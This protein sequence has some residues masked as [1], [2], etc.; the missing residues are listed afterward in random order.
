MSITTTFARLSRTALSSCSV[1][2]R[3]RCDSIKRMIGTSSIASRNGRSAHSLRAHCAIGA[4]TDPE[5]LAE[6]VFD[7]D[8]EQGDA[9]D[10]EPTAGLRFSIEAGRHRCSW[11]LFVHRLHGRNKDPA[12]DL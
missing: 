2:A 12:A 11:A 5:R 8:D 6:Q 7:E 3:A 4:P 9:V 10:V 1:K